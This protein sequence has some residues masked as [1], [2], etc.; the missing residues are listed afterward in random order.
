MTADGGHV[1][2]LVGRLV[3]QIEDARHTLHRD[4]TP[5]NRCRRI[6]LGLAF[7]RPKDCDCGLDALLAEA[8]EFVGTHVPAPRFV[9]RKDPPINAI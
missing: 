3:Y 8:Q 7:S 5:T 4:E 1:I 2:D 9:P 6:E